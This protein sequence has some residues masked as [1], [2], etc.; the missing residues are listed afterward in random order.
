MYNSKTVFIDVSTKLRF[1][2]PRTLLTFLA[3]VWYCL[4]STT[5]T[6]WCMEL[7]RAVFSMLLHYT[8][9][10]TSQVDCNNSAAFGDPQCT[11]VSNCNTIVS[12]NVRLSYW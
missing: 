8:V 3:A 12:G 6:L 2:I 9:A 10:R 5:V 4:D 11:S 7:Q 1:I